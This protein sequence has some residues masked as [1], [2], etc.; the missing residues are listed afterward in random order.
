MAIA[1]RV[2]AASRLGT[3][4][5]GKLAAAYSDRG[6][7]QSNLWYVYS[8]RTGRD[9]VLRSDLQWGH[10]LLAESD[11]YIKDS[12]Y[13]PPTKLQGVGGDN[14]A[15]T[16]DAI[17]TLKNGT[18]E[19]REI[20]S[21]DAIENEDFGSQHQREVQIEAAIR[22][23]VRYVRYSEHDI[24]ACPQRIANWA[25]VIAWLAAVRGRSLYAEGV[26]VA[27]LLH[28]RGSVSIGEIQDIAPGSKGVC[29]VAAAFKG[30]Q[31]GLFASDLNDR[32]LSRNSLV[33]S[34]EG[35]A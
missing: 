11:P 32:P 5:R 18:V 4:L 25:R 21:S 12:D 16:L 13:S 1:A 19:W 35:P 7:H 33:K 24:Y 23:G 28:A 29:F 34:I 14:Q 22:L 26:E 9:W 17:V 3:K 30:V 15:S 10:F 2:K 6:H 27:A 20:K 31:D 8:P